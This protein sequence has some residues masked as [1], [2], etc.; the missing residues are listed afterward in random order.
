MAEAFVPGME[1]HEL[2]KLPALIQ[3][4]QKHKKQEPKLN[5][6]TF[7]S[8]HYQ[9]PEHHEEDSQTHH[10]LPFS[11]H[12][13]QHACCQ[14]L[15]FQVSFVIVKPQLTPLHNIGEVIYQEPAVAD[16]SSAIWQPPK[17]S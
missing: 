8:L 6:F 17:I 10:K 1:L 15:A 2:S 13:N 16:L 12:H 5:F 14:Q 11:A 7:V 3:H 9:N 4:Y